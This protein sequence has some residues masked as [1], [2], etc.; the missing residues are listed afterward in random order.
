MKKLFA[1]LF[2]LV[3]LVAAIALWFLYNSGIVTLSGK[4]QTYHGLRV[5]AKLDNAAV[6]QSLLEEKSVKISGNHCLAILEMA[7]EDGWEVLKAESYKDGGSTHYQLLLSRSQPAVDMTCRY[8]PKYGK[9]TSTEISFIHPT[10]IDNW[11]NTSTN[12]Y[13]K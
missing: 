5:P 1:L 7:G 2:L 6:S 10:K 12:P 13:V 9:I 3:V 8:S 11:L 4:T